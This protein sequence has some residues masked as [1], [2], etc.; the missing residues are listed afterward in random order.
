MQKLLEWLEGKKTYI[1]MA[2]LFII[3]GLQANGVDVPDWTYAILGAIGL[4][5]LRAAVARK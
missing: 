1:T 3:G 4:G 5:S 2:A